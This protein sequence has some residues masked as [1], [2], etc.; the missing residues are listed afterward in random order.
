M[1]A[2]SIRYFLYGAIKQLKEE[3]SK[4]II[5]RLE[6]TQVVNSLT[7]WEALYAHNKKWG[8]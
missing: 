1:I 2:K 5:N 8:E 7:D 6:P 4:E 3:Q